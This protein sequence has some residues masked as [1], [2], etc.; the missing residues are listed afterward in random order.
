MTS[1][2]VDVPDEIAET[3]R[4]RFGSVGP[5][6]GLDFLRGDANSNG[7]LPRRLIEVRATPSAPDCVELAG[8]IRRRDFKANLDPAWGWIA[9][10]ERGR[11]GSICTE[12][13][14]E[15]RHKNLASAL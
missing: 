11:E 1:S 9:Q 3:S 13:E 5:Q 7:C 8:S 10:I 12:Q 2:W 15:Q 4:D 6:L 14:H